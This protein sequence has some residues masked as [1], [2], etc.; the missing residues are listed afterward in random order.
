MES[1][2]EL[3]ETVDFEEKCTTSKQQ[4]VYKESTLWK[5][6]S[7]ETPE[8]NFEKVRRMSIDWNQE[9]ISCQAKLSSTQQRLRASNNL[10]LSEFDLVFWNI[11]CYHEYK[12][13]KI[14]INKMN[15]KISFNF[16]LFHLRDNIWGLVIKPMEVVILADFFAWKKIQFSKNVSCTKT[17]FELSSLYS[18]FCCF[19][20]NFNIIF[21]IST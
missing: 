17:K 19:P 8:T 6:C 16:E 20:M 10:L 7:K 9:I 3:L 11:F 1:N 14:T 21:R 5:I 12:C 18:I 15:S 2:T 13:I 4:A